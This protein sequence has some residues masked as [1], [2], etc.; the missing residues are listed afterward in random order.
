[1]FRGQE[2]V[3]SGV[4]IILSLKKAMGILSTK[5]FLSFRTDNELKIKSTIFNILPV[6]LE[7][8]GWKK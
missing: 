1:M 7:S 3:I 2:F 6:A 8:Q 4:E 5:Y